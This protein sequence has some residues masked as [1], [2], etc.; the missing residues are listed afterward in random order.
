MDD[1]GNDEKQ[2][3]EAGTPSASDAS[4]GVSLKSIDRL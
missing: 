3:E 4:S 2:L 1:G